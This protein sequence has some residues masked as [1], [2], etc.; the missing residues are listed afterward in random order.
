MN[1]EERKGMKN[2]LDIMMHSN[3]ALMHENDPSDSGFAA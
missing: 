3:D 1:H 2:N